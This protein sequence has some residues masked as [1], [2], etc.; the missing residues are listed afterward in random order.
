M[1][2]SDKGKIR[3]YKQQLQVVLESSISQRLTTA[4]LWE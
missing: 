2:S 3:C 4:G 1:R